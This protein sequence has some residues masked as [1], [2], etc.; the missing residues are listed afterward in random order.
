MTRIQE[1]QKIEPIGLTSIQERSVEIP[2]DT[3]LTHLQ[4]RRFAGCPMCSTHMRS[5]VQRHDELVESGIQ[6]VAVFHSTRDAMM[7]H[8]AEA[9]F[10][11]VADPSKALYRRFGVETSIRAVLHPDAWRAAISGVASRNFS[12]P[13]MGESPLGLPAD[14]L[15]DAEGRVAACKYGTH[16]YDHWTVDEVIELGARASR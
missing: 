7:R 13:A 12:M 9:P 2:A 15:I 8:H 1:G 4:F 6:E 16:A 10:A 11:L 14:F 3:K 5:F